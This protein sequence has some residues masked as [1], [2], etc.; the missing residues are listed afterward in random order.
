MCSSDLTPAADANGTATFQVVL[1]DDGGT[2]NGGTDESAA[3][4]FTITVNPMPEDDDDDDVIIPSSSGGGGGCQLATGHQANGGTP[5]LWPW[6][7][8]LAATLAIGRRVG[9]HSRG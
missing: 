8:A 6:L 7:V 1:R 2:A 5:G 9:V 3:K 4:T